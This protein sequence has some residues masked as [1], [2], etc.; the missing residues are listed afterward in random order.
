MFNILQ[1][2]TRWKDIL[3]RLRRR[4]D[5]PKDTATTQLLQQGSPSAQ[6]QP[7]EIQNDSLEPKE[8]N[9]TERH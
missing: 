1:T 4:D 9:N 5:K 8:L 2:L 6:V 7:P 3:Q